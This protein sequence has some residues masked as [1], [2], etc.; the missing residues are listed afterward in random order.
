M[1]EYIDGELLTPDN[2]TTELGQKAL[3][4]LRT[5]HHLGIVHGDT[6]DRHTIRNVLVKKDQEVIWF[7]FERSLIDNSREDLMAIE[8]QIAAHFLDYGGE[9]SKLR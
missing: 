8:D 2:F 3:L 9:M 1:L 6:D 5:L 7:D 4:C